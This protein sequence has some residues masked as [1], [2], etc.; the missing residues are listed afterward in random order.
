MDIYAAPGTKVLF[1][2]EGGHP[3]ESILAQQKLTIGEVYT[4]KETV[5]DDWHTDV[6]LEE[7]PGAFN[8]VMFED[9]DV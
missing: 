8:S 1:T 6:F 4:I 9:W 3:T 7:A 5:V 2:G